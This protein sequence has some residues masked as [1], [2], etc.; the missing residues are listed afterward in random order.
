MDL[1][2]QRGRINIS[3]DKDLASLLYK[4]IHVISK[5]LTQYQSS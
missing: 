4:T 5:I 2:R 1:Y 3:C